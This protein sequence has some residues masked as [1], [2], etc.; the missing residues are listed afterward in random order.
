[1]STEE[2]INELEGLRFILECKRDRERAETGVFRASSSRLVAIN[3]AISLLRT[4]PDAQPN[5]PLTLEEL[6]EMV[7]QPVWVQFPDFPEYGSWRIV[8]G[9][10][11]EGGERTL[12]CWGDYTCRDYGETRL[13]YRRPPKDGGAP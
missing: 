12:Y 1:M 6:R 13:A 2:I 4:H 7:N 3:A 9:V 10:N 5:E 8:V 11:T